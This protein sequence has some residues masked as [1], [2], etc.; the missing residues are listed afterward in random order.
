MPRACCRSV[1]PAWVGVTPWRPR[2]SSEAPS[3][4]SMLRTR[5]E[6]AVS[7]RWARSA[8]CVMLPASTIWRKRLRSTKSKCMA[9]PFAVHE[10]RV[11]K[12]LIVSGTF[13]SYFVSR[14]APR[15]PQYTIGY[16]ELEHLDWHPCRLMREHV[17]REDDNGRKQGPDATAV[18][19]RA[20]LSL[21]AAHG[22][23]DPAS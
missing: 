20:D 11:R 10:G 12:I 23:V 3:A 8:P 21:A 22:D 7:A 13:T 2:T 18:A 6:A 9:E 1:R 15:A 16:G 17:D 19:A 4:S 5:V 14:E